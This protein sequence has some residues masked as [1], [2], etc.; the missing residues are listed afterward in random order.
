M[1]N[2]DRIRKQLSPARRRTIAA[3]TATL[4][5]EQ[6]SLQ[7]LRQA[8]ELTQKR[9]A[10]GVI[11]SRAEI[12]NRPSTTAGSIPAARSSTAR[13]LTRSRRVASCAA[14]RAKVAC[15]EWHLP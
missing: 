12:M 10:Q 5:A 6:R 4:I 13:T 15:R 9:M 14:R 8:H 11:S 1:T 7:E 3:R 2:L